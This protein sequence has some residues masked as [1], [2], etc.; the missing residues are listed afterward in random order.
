MD[1]DQLASELRALRDRID[2]LE[3]SHI[4]LKRRSAPFFTPC[5]TTTKIAAL[6]ALA[7]TVLALA[8][9]FSPQSIAIG[10]WRYESSG[11]SIEAIAALGAAVGVFI[12]LHQHLKDKNDYASTSKA[13]RDQIDF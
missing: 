2:D 1:N 8:F 11:I 12:T 9:A 10:G 13:S 5:R 6:V 4:A 7:L 3:V